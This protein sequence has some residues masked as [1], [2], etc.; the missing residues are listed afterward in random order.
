MPESGK[1]VLRW[2]GAAGLELRA[3][4]TTVVVDPFFSRFPFWRLWLGRVSPITGLA[5]R[6]VPRCSHILVTHAHWDHLLDAP[7]LAKA[8]GAMV[9]GSANTCRLAQAAGVDSR[10][11]RE[12]HPGDSVDLGAFRVE[13]FETTHGTVLGRPY[14]AGPLPPGLRFPA[15]AGDYRMDV[16]LGFRFF[17]GGKPLLS[18]AGEKPEEVR[19]AP[20]VAVAVHK[21]PG[22]YRRLLETSGARVVIPIHWDDLFRSLGPAGQQPRPMLHPPALAWP[23]LRRMDVGVFRRLLSDIRP[24]VQVITPQVFE[25]CD[26][27]HWSGLYHER[28]YD[29]APVSGGPPYGCAVVVFR[30]SRGRFEYLALHRSHE[31]PGYDSNWAWGPAAGA[32]LP[33]ETVD[34]CAARELKEET[35]LSADTCVQASGD[36]R[37]W[38]V[39]WLEAEKDAT[40]RLSREHDRYAWLPLAEAVALS[41]PALVAQEYMSVAKEIGDP[42]IKEMVT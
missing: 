14:N 8:T 19:P 25:E 39:Y 15:R 29:G 32:R 40:V 18:L 37:D 10:T 26:L 41:L 11:I 16:C 2:L 17:V 24:E 34:H 1:V 33:D 4:W 7:D 20:I 27:S 21:R 30:R 31:G 38:P 23:P 13:V 28:T 6:H 5:S 3:G 42:A 12:V 36:N 22:Y 9:L 35:G